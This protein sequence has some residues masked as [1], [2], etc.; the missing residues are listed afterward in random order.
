MS[1]IFNL[2]HDTRKLVFEVFDQV[3]HKPSCTEED[4][5]LEILD[6]R[7]R[8]IVLYIYRNKAVDQLCSYCTA[9][10]RLRFHLAKLWLSHDMA[11]LIFGISLM[12]VYLI[13]S[14][15]KIVNVNSYYF[16]Y[17]TQIFI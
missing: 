2:S 8:G 7:R 4:W 11:H 12:L 9:N 10:L 16:A 17:F 6:F 14:E 13:W 5:K 15:K 3:R 1:N